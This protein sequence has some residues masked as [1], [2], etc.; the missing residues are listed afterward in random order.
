MTIP[1]L[2]PSMT[3]REEAAV[4]EVLRSGWIGQGPKC[5]E[6]ESRLAERYGYEYAI[7]TNSATAALHL[8]CLANNIGPGDEVIVPALTFISTALAVSYCGAKPVFADVD[9]D[10][11]CLDWIDVYN[12]MTERTK[13]IIPVDYAGYP[14]MV[15]GV[16][17]GKPIIQDAAHANGG[18]AYGQEVCFSFH[19]VKNLATSDGGAVLTN[20]HAKAERMKA[21][22]WCGIN[23]STWERSDKKYGWD[24]DITE[25][26]FK[27]H[28][29]DLAAAI[30]LVQLERLDEMNERRRIIAD[31]YT[32]HLAN[33]VQTP[34]H[35]KNSTNHLYA[36]RVDASKR[37]AL[38]DHL[39]SKGISAGCHYKPLTLYK[40]YC[41][42][43][44]P[45][46]TNREWQRLVSLPI[47][48]DLTDDNQVHVIDSI[49]EFFRG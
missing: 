46:V 42:Q 14:A 13:A 30:G 44:T 12:K 36:I 11:L 45:P 1:L 41:D 6:F 15:S 37:N 33:Y 38:I 34:I 22:R 21:L 2:K 19:A 28:L 16:N 10:T 49:K 4:L 24:Y 17:L 3:V 27:C 29:S 23:K 32:C 18:L 47:F 25:I 26:G 48:F 43:P 31:R 35:H 40:P 8:A 5:A 7:T 20:D 39:L 9:L